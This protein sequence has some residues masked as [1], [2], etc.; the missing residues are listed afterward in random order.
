MARFYFRVQREP[1]III[2]ATET[3]NLVGPG[4]RRRRGQIIIIRSVFVTVKKNPLSGT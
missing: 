4:K 2:A 3:A 1:I